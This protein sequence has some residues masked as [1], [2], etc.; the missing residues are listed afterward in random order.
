MSTQV[1]ILPSVYEM[2]AA[3]VRVQTFR[4]QPLAAVAIAGLEIQ[5]H[6]AE[7]IAVLAAMLHRLGDELTAAIQVTA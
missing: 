6:G 2:E 5:T 7:H 4:D 3:Q 1:S